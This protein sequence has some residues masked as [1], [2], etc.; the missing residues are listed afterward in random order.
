MTGLLVWRWCQVAPPACPWG[1][2]EGNLDR[3][4]NNVHRD[5]AG[6]LGP[7]VEL[8]A[9]SR[10]VTSVPDDLAKQYRAAL[11][12][13]AMA[14]NGWEPPGKPPSRRP[15]GWN[16]VSASCLCPRN[17]RIAGSTLAVGEIIRSVCGQPFMP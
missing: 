14:L 6:A 15:R 1:R 4:H 10:S 9:L 13:I 16:L 2:S 5:T 3:Y 11:D 12:R 17:I 8:D 7:E